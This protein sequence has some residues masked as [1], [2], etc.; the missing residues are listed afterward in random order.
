MQ[1]ARQKASEEGS[2]HASYMQVSVV[3]I[4]SVFNMLD[5][6]SAISIPMF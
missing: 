1:K 6:V 2:L 4:D 3:E 5:L